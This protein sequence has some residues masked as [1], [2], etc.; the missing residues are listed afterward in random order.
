MRI[1]TASVR[2]IR[3]APSAGEQ[4]AA[5]HS[6]VETS[7]LC[8]EALYQSVSLPSTVQLIVDS[9]WGYALGALST[10]PRPVLV[11]T[12]TPSVHYLRDLLDLDPEGLVATPVSPE[13][14]GRALLR[15]AK[16][17]SFYLGPPLGE[18]FIGPREREVLRLVAVG[19][20]TGRSLACWDS[21][22]E[23]L[24]TVSQPYGTSLA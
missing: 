2:R 7:R 5:V 16:G 14:V 24:R 15:V 23:R 22:G 3:P 18:H 11:V 17:E 8:G 21:L 9:P 10:L 13:E 4:R 20:G 19:L 6:G 1:P 12:E